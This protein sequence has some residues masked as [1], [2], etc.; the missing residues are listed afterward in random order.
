MILLLLFFASLSSGIASRPDTRTHIATENTGRSHAV[1]GTK[2]GTS[3]AALQGLLP[4]N[5]HFIQLAKRQTPPSS[6]AGKP[7]V[8]SHGLLLDDICRARNPNLPHLPEIDRTV[9]G[10]DAL[11]GALHMTQSPFVNI[12]SPAHIALASLP[13][14]QQEYYVEVQKQARGFSDQGKNA[15]MSTKSLAVLL[16]LEILYHWSDLQQLEQGLKRSEQTREKTHTPHMS[17]VP[18]DEDSTGGKHSG[19]LLELTGTSSPKRSGFWHRRYGDQPTRENLARH[20]R[21]MRQATPTQAKDWMLSSKDNLAQQSLH[22]PQAARYQV[23]GSLPLGPELVSQ[24]ARPRL[25]RLR[26]G[27]RRALDGI[28]Y[29]P[30]RV[31]GFLASVREGLR[32][33]D[34]DHSAGWKGVKSQVG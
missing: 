6:K 11:R 34:S 5:S 23:A 22:L 14:R 3:T 29:A 7:I 27:V 15:P 1:S 33:K 31:R 21:L 30:W 18:V 24:P 4:D 8:P 16:I 32:G 10:L 13:K 25:R 12:I 20:N 26:N 2:P 9:L 17:Q 28:E 19:P